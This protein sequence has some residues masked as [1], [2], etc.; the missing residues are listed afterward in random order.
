MKKRTLRPDRLIMVL[1]TFVLIIWILLCLFSFI[2]NKQA[3]NR[4]KLI[5]CVEV[6]DKIVNLNVDE[7]IHFE[8]TKK[9]PLRYTLNKDIK[10][11]EVKK[12]NTPI[13]EEIKIEE[14]V[15]EQQLEYLGK[16]LL[17]AYCP[18][19]LCSEGYGKMTSTGAIAEQGRTIAVDPNIIPYGT[20]VIIDGHTYIAEDCGGAINDNHIDIF[21]ENHEDCYADWCNG[22]HDVYIE[23]E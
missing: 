8:K 22:Y 5:T 14:E 1:T 7:F 13:K 18:C 3:K 11:E 2:D 6:D 21:V 9:L 19:E 16:F 20:N 10:K 12:I 15:V 4:K 23:V 17:T